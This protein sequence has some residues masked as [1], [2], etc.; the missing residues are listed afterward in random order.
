MTK[1][2]HYFSHWFRW[3]TSPHYRDWYGFPGPSD[4]PCGGYGWWDE[5]D[6]CFDCDHNTRMDAWCRRPEPTWWRPEPLVSTTASE[7]PD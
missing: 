4:C 5:Y 3:L 1:L 2:T 7:Q 6:Q